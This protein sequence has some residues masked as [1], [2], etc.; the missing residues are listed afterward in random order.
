MSSATPTLSP[1]AAAVRDHAA[2]AFG[3]LYLVSHEHDEAAREVGAMCKAE[4][5][6][7]A[8][9]D[10]DRGLVADGAEDA[11]VLT[12]VAALHALA[13]LRDRAGQANVVLLLRNFHLWLRNPQVIQAVAN[14]AAAGKQARTTL[15]VLAPSVAIPPE[16]ARLFAVIEHELP[17][18]AQLGELARGV[19]TEPG[20]LPEG[21]E[22][23]ALL[24]SSAGLTRYEAEN[25]YALALVRRGRLDPAE[26]WELKAQAVR[27]SGLM[28]LHRGG[29]RFADLGGLDALKD[30]CA[31]SLRRTPGRPAAAKARGVMLLGTPGTGKSQFAKALGNESG[32]PTLVL[33]VGALMGSH[34]GETEGNLRAALALADAMAPAILFVDEV[35]KALAGSESSG[36]TDGGVKAGILGTLLTWLSDHASDVYVVTTAN[37]IDK[38]PPAFLRSER[39]DATF[40]VDFPGAAA[41][42]AIWGLYL[43]RFGLDRD[44][45]RPA[46]EG[47]TGADIRACCRQAAVLGVPVADAARYVVP[48]ART[49]GRS[50]QALREAATDCYLDAERPGL[51]SHRGPAP[52]ASD[53]PSRGR[54][55]RRPAATA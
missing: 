38:L 2:A 54:A 1:L 26:V 18:R 3:A 25:A 31:R 28:E 36:E 20:E 8:E 24:E 14:A 35:E 29:E 19:A 32:R 33:D 49:A 11:S 48:V 6:R 50:V 12:P 13:A 9:W 52:A 34:L 40:F 23:E 4:G 42:E 55:I 37:S 10:C 27:K 51:Y 47:W 43:A 39:F 7:L 16:L 5:W 41:R 21:A 44:Q 22:F 53:E 45:P 17:D 46:D 30:Y 15:V